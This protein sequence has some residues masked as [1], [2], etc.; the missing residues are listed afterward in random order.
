MTRRAAIVLNLAAA[1]L[2]TMA[3]S[4][5][6]AIIAITNEPGHL[7]FGTGS[8][9]GENNIGGSRS[10]HT[11]TNFALNG[12]N[13]VVLFFA[14][15]GSS[16]GSGNTIQL[17][18]TYGGQAMTVVQ[19]A[20]G[21]GARFQG[22]IAYIINP[23]VSTGNIVASWLES[24]EGLIEAIALS[25][26]ASVV[27]SN[28]TDSSGTANNTLNYTT[29]VD[30]G[31]VAG[32]GLNNTFNGGA[33]SAPQTTGLT[34]DL[35]RGNISGNFAAV[36]AYSQIAAAGNGS[37]TVGG[38]PIANSSALVAFEAVPEP[39]SLAI[40]G[41]GGLLIGNRRRG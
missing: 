14:S 36:F 4:T 19:S 18:A 21:T 40:L 37:A 3:T 24:S 17:S 2:A 22:S 23:N 9:P 15:E 12:G 25:N 1:S 32:A 35:Y 29:T 41:L 6:A 38:S 11:I 26:V 34:T 10:S 27:A 16:S 31:F 5:N 33:P 39:A 30:G 7:S 28:S 8:Q 13:A 20:G